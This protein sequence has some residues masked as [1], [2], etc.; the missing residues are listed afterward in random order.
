MELVSR[1]LDVSPVSE[2]P[3][4]IYGLYSNVLD[5][6]VRAISQNST[7]MFF[8]FVLFSTPVFTYPKAWA[9]T[10]YLMIINHIKHILGARHY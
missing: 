2:S 9:I 8:G 3:L 6:G 7:F 5:M 1:D 4:R 10:G